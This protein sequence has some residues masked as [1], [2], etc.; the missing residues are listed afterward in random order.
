MTYEKNTI[1]ITGT[2]WYQQRLLARFFAQELRR[3]IGSNETVLSIDGVNE[4]ELGKRVH[5]EDIRE[6]LQDRPIAISIPAP[7]RVVSYDLH[8]NGEPAFLT[9]HFSGIAEHSFRGRAKKVAWELGVGVISARVRITAVGVDADSGGVMIRAAAAG[10][11]TLD[12][13]KAEIEQYVR[14]RLLD[15]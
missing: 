4:A 8:S 1:T 14:Q 11:P 13:M 12:E 5:D 3:A 10:R 9:M 2:V 6:A 15:D 7:A